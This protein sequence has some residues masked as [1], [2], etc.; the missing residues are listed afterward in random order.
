MSHGVVHFEIPGDDPEKLSGFYSSL[1]DWKINKM[2]MGEGPDYWVVSTVDTNEQG[3][4]T[5]AGA[6]NGGIY[7]RTDPQ[8]RPI[9]YVAVESVDEY[10]KKATALGATVTLQK[11]PIPGMGFFAQLT[12]PQ[13]NPFAL[14]QNEGSAS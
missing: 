8:M 7:K 11:T 9:N 12:D 4:P 10:L 13:G 1:F 5:E 2:A 6:I 14:F 3:M